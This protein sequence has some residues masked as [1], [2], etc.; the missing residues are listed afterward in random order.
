MKTTVVK[1]WLIN[2]VKQNRGK[3][4]ETFLAVQEK[5]RER[6]IEE[7][8]KR[9]ALAREG[10]RVDL[11]V[12]LVEPKDQTRDYDRIIGMLEKSTETDITLDEK[13]YERYV[14]DRWDWKDQ[15]KTVSATYGVE[16]ED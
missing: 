1:A 3:H 6:V 4:R 13:D 14:M 15:W 11:Y 8:E 5:F 9:L 10:R 2:T 12:H 7:F 16:V